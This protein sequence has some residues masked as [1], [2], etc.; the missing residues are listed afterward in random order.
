VTALIQPEAVHGAGRGALQVTDDVGVRQAGVGNAR[1]GRVRGVQ[2]LVGLTVVDAH[3]RR[4]RRATHQHVETPV[5]HAHPVQ[6]DGAQREHRPPGL[7]GHAQPADVLQAQ[8]LQGG[9]T[10]GDRVQERVGQAALTVQVQG[11]DGRGPT[12][13]GA[14]HPANVRAVRAG[15]FQA[16]PFPA[17]LAQRFFKVLEPPPPVVRPQPMHRRG[18]HELFSSR[19][20]R[21]QGRVPERPVDQGHPAPV[22]ERQVFQD[23]R[24]YL[25]NSR[26][27][28]TETLLRSRFDLTYYMCTM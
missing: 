7:V 3:V 12:G 19:Q 28:K 18:V 5:G 22:V 23:F 6:A 2:P 14:E 4:V 15:E 11:H 9:A 8:L 1:G 20:R 17:G 25:E 10:V 27:I 21:V 13:A 26:A 24:D 16:Q